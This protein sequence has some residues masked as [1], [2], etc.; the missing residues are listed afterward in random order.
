MGPRIKQRIRTRA[1]L[2]EIRASAA[3]EG[4]RTMLQDG[5]EKVFEGLTDFRQVRAACVV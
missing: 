5:I 3:E 2:D 4:V 1:H